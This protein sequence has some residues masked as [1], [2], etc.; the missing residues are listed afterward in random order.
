M[1][2]IERVRNATFEQHELY[3][4]VLLHTTLIM[5]FVKRIIFIL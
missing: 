4:S 5:V 2:L 1:E 3:L